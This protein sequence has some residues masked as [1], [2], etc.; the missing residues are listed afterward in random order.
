MPRKAQPPPRRGGK[1]DYP[2]L[3]HWAWLTGI[4]A[5]LDVLVGDVSAVSLRV[6][7]TCFLAFLAIWLNLSE[8]STMRPVLGLAT[9]GT[10]ICSVIAWGV[11]GSRSQM[12]PSTTLAW[13][14]VSF[15]GVV[16]MSLLIV[17]SALYQDRAR[18]SVRSAEADKQ[19][20]DAE[21]SQAAQDE[22]ARQ[23][24]IADEASKR[25]HEDEAARQRAQA[26]TQSCVLARDD[27]IQKA[28]WSLSGARKAAEDCQTQWKE[29]LV[30]FQNDRE[31]CKGPYSRFDSAKAQ[32]ADAKSKSCGEGTDTT[33][34]VDK[35]K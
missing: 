1:I 33:G 17:S 13:H 18:A 24:K 14:R 27:A 12:R 30:T 20:H 6:A 4:P 10:L 21:V 22:A 16:A 25:A 23:A 3:F 26:A 29:T 31:F 2:D 35:R 8:D 7:P 9:V 15:W 11:Q 5:K 19:R 28:T 34:S 32:L